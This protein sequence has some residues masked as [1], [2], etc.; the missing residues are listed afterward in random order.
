[1]KQARRL[2]AGTTMTL[3][4]IAE[5]LDMGSWICASNLPHEKH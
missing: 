3:R 4:W 2:R 1:V 5:G